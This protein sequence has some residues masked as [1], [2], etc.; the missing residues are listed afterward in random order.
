MTDVKFITEKLAN[1]IEEFFQR[2]SHKIIEKTGYNLKIASVGGTFN[3][4]RMVVEIGLLPS[5]AQ[6]HRY[7]DLQKDMD[8]KRKTKRNTSPN[9][10]RKLV[11]FTGYKES[12]IQRCVDDWNNNQ[13]NLKGVDFKIGSKFAKGRILYLVVGYNMR[14][15]K[16]VLYNNDKQK[17]VNYSIS[18]IYHMD[19]L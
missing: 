9:L 3:K 15:D 8:V 13:D 4:E 12:Q 16:V 6:K 10:V 18:A 19:K 11:K 17:L 7:V 5:D 1:H 2:N 14:K